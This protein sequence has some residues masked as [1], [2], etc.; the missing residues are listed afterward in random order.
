[1]DHFNEE[2]YRLGLNEEKEKSRSTEATANVLTFYNKHQTICDYAYLYY[3]E[4][5]DNINKYVTKAEMIEAEE[6]IAVM[7]DIKILA[8]TANTIER[9]ILIR[10]LSEQTGSPLH[11]YRVGK[12]TCNV[13]HLGDNKSVIHVS[14]GKT[15]EEYTRKAINRVCRVFSPNYLCLVGI[16]YGLNMEKYTIGSVFISESVKTFRLNFRDEMDSDEVTF[17]VEDEY[18]E[19]PSSDFIQSIRDMLMYT[20]MF[21]ILSTDEVPISANSKLGRFLSCNSLMSSRKVKRAV[22][23][24]YNNKGSEPLG[25]EM[26]GAGILK[27]N[28]VEEQGFN[29]WLIVKSVCDWGEKKNALD[30]NPIR[31]DHIKESLQAYAM[32]N[33][34]GVFGQLLELCV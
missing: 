3:K 15:G 30:L 1:M 13:C 2:E 12:L 22:V 32:T 29:K 23:D 17:E 4:Y 27:S 10:W 6:F 14:P 34:C 16:C 19:H 5:E 11:T 25:G 28:V 33:T 20:Q 31:N 24:Q 7:K 26:E 9:G 21:S 18:D 8:M